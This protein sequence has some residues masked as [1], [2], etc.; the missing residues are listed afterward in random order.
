VLPPG[1]TFCEPGDALNE[2]PDPTVTLAGADGMPFAITNSWLAPPSVPMGT[3]KFVDTIVPPV[4][5][6]IVL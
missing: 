6:P 5:T 4:A 2:K 1:T 3:S